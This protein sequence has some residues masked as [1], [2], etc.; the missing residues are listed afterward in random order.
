VSGPV[1]VVLCGGASSRMG[2]DKATLGP[3]ERPL[4]AHVAGAVRDAG[5][6]EVVLVGGDSDRLRAH[7]DL[8]LADDRPGE[9]P[10]AA[11][12]TAAASRPG[13]TLLV[14]ACDLPVVTGADLR[15]LL[16][17]V[18]AGAPAAVADVDGRPQWSAVA[19]SAPVAASLGAAVAAGERALHPA[20]PA[21]VV[22]LEPAVPDHLRD[23]DRPADLPDGLRPG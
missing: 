12:V 14:C 11:V 16:D 7:G 9:G 22:H 17:A 2:T 1:G 5:V 20:L 15:P 19:V 4:A 3:P 8:W 23:A 10:L 6:Y 18:A 21:G 13:R